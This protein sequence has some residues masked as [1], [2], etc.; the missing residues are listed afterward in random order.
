MHF[1]VEFICFKEQIRTVWLLC[2]CFLA[3]TSKFPRPQS[4]H[5]LVRMLLYLHSS[6]LKKTFPY[7]D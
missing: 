6:L 2:H 1:T 7:S 5:G 3:V 4:T